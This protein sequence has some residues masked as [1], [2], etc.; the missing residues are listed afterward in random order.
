[1]K[2]WELNEM[3][4]DE[5]ECLECRGTG[6]FKCFK[7]DGVLP[8]VYDCSECHGD[9]EVECEDCGGSGVEDWR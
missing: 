3:S 7:C 2:K 6:T 4:E 8:E 9:G 5:K 1:M